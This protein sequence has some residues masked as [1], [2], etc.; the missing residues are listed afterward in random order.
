MRS[1]QGE[2]EEGRC[3]IVETNYRMYAY[4]RSVLQEQVLRLFAEVCYKLPHML[5]GVITRA[6]IRNAL[7]KGISAAQIID[8]LQMHAH[9]QVYSASCACTLCRCARGHMR[10]WSGRMYALHLLPAGMLHLLPCGEGARCAIK[11]ESFWWAAQLAQPLH[12]D[13]CGGRR[14]CTIAM[15]QTHAAC[16]R[17]VVSAV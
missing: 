13:E 2:V 16:K 17:P 14:R 3:V 15:V 6:S 11:L 8:Y 9:P 12:L 1:M 7:T 5:I 4:T 10:C